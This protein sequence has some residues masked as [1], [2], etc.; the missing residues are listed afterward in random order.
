MNEHA[1]NTLA[2]VALAAS[3][4]TWVVQIIM[5]CGGCTPVI[6]YLVFFVAPLI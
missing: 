1:T 3:I 4:V 5:F 2:S 6:N